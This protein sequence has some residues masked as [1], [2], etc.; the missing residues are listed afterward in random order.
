M[1]GFLTI[2]LASGATD[3]QFRS[4]GK[5]PDV[6]VVL[7]LMVLQYVQKGF[8]WI[9]FILDN[10]RTHRADMGLALQELLS[11]I[12]AMTGWDDLQRCTV[13]FLH[14][15]AYSPALNPAEYLIH[16]VRQSALYHL[17]CTFTLQDKADRVR[18]HLAQ[19]PPFTPQQMKRLL[20]HIGRLPKTA[21]DKNW[22]KL[23]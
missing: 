14:T 2:D 8:H 19:G 12:A 18:D 4:Q 10:A 16:Q 13:A 6:I 20:A 23:E 7:A 22:A 11:E 5:T 21:H 3:V 17:P 9:T 1:T 15:P